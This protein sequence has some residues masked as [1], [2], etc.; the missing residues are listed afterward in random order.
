MFRPYYNGHLQASILGGAI[1]TTAIRNIRDLVSRVNTAVYIGI[2]TFP[3][4]SAPSV[5]RWSVYLST[6]R[7]CAVCGWES[8]YYFSGFDSRCPWCF[9]LS[10]VHTIRDMRSRTLRIAIVFITPPSIEA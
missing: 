7:L 8:K 5:W 1:N 10:G 2:Y 3:A 4:P 9:W 6:G